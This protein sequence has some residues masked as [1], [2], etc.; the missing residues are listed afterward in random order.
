MKKFLIIIV[1]IIL[2][3]I[4]VGYLV[5]INKTDASVAVTNEY[6]ATTTAQGT[7]ASTTVL[8]THSAT[9]GSVVIL[10]AAAQSINI[11][12]ATTT[13]I[14]KRTGNKATSTLI[15]ATIPASLAAGT[16]TFD[17]ST[18]TGLLI[19]IVGTVT[20]PNAVITYRYN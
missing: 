17:V 12:D 10:T 16:Y 15:V 14:T 5:S 19:D 2:V 20:M 4:A 8:S 1:G 18:V 11:I 6:I 13:D 9:L 3:G 7:F